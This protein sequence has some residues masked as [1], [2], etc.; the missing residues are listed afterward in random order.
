LLDD[1][2]V[3][4]LKQDVAISRLLRSVCELCAGVVDRKRG[5]RG[6]AEL[7]EDLVQVR[8]DRSV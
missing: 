4:H 1:V 8:A 2:P 7:R 6:D 5:T 3:A